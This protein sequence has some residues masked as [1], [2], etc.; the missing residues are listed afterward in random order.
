MPVAAK[1][2]YLRIAP[3]KVR[4]VADLIRG[5]KT[6]R[7]NAILSF[8]NKA[9]TVP[10]LKLLKSAL[11][12]AKNNFGLEESNLYIAKIFVNEGPTLKRWRARARGQAY[13]IMK[14]TSHVTLVLD[15][16]AKTGKADKKAKKTRITTPEQEL[17]EPAAEKEIKK[18]KQKPRPDLE[19]SRPRIE[20]ESRRVFRRKA[21]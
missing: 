3:R 1:L 7:A 9:A 2:Q 5:K 17:K 19:T 16:I 14:R 8:T 18:E 21:F 20:K 11:A 12:N 4:S 6:E 15:E 10:L 13:E